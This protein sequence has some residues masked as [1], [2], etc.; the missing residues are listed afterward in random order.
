[1]IWFARTGFGISC[2]GPLADGIL[3]GDD[4]TWAVLAWNRIWARRLKL[5]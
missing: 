4:A 3:A 5:K 1:M 2:N